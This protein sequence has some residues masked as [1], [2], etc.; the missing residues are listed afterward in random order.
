M[1]REQVATI[2]YAYARAK[3]YDVSA[4]ADLSG[5]TDASSVSSY[6][7]GAMS[8]AVGAGLISGIGNNLVAPQ[9]TATR[10]QFAVM[11]MNFC[12]NIVE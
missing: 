6:A 3:G 12:E 8:W 7:D 4:A 10:A 2:L 1:T 11:L 5:Y 9:G